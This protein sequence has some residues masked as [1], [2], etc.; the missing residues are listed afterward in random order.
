M[1]D[2]ENNL[3][4]QIIPLLQEYDKDGLINLED[5]ERKQLKNGSIPDV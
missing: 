2:F 1:K 4:Y 3:K 5:A